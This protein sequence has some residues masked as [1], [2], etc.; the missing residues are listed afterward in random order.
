MMVWMLSNK[1][2]LLFDQSENL[3]EVFE[4]VWFTEHDGFTSGLSSTGTTDTVYV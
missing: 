2:D 1:W 3:L 4:F